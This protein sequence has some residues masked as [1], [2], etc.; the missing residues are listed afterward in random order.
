MLAKITDNLPGTR[1]GAIHASLGDFGPSGLRT[2]PRGTICGV[3][4]ENS[5]WRAVAVFRVGALAYAIFLTANAYEIYD[6]PVLGWTVIAGMAVWTGV[7]T[8]A[9]GEPRRRDWPLLLLDLS[10]ACVALYASRFVIDRQ[11]LEQG[12]AT[13]P[14]AWVAGPVLAC[15][16]SPKD[17]GW[18]R[19]RPSPWE[20]WTG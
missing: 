8:W 11:L 4:L 10:V 14:M 18:P 6:R 3:G 17:V 20:R 5:L 7:A 1:H 12:V 9:Y 15:R 19:W 16:A 2:A 13:L